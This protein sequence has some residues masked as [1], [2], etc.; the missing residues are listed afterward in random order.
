MSLL[1]CESC[2]SSPFTHSLIPSW[3]GSATSPAGT[4]QGPSGHEP[5]K[6]FWLTQS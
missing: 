1:V 5:S 6:H 4:I 3:W 2:I